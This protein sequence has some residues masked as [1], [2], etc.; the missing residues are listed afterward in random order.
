MA[1]AVRRSPPASG[2]LCGRCPGRLGL[3]GQSPQPRRERVHRGAGTA[4]RIGAPTLHRRD[5]PART[6]S[7]PPFDPSRASEAPADSPSVPGRR[8][9]RR[10]GGPVS[11]RSSQGRPRHGSGGGARGLGTPSAR[12]GARARGP[13]PG[14][15]SA[16]RAEAGCRKGEGGKAQG[17]EARGPGARV[18]R[19]WACVC[20]VCLCVRAHTRLGGSMRIPARIPEAS[21][22]LVLQVRGSPTH[23]R[24]YLS[25]RRYT[26]E[27]TS[28][29][30]QTARRPA[31][32]TPIRRLQ[33]PGPR[34]QA[35]QPCLSG[36]SRLSAKRR[37]AAGSTSSMGAAPATARPAPHPA[38]RRQA[39]GRGNSRVWY[40]VKIK[41]VKDLP[42]NE[43][44]GIP[45]QMYQSTKV[46]RAAP[47]G[48]RH[49]ASDTA[50]GRIRTGN[51]TL[52]STPS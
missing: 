6:A 34:P 24:R 50:Q 49:S 38:V 40:R 23:T 44:L 10:D 42:I 14:P 25:V 16:R 4:R 31:P 8:R 45:R 37:S 48:R 39:R 51:H 15:G 36:S 43:T 12:P 18:V 41:K 5:A 47:Q 33:A 20:V 27:H 35:G 28:K 19:R 3:G 7:S 46:L 29:V 26:T 22:F 32:R 11:A 13:R 52:A 30:Y 1:A 9:R 2:L 17:T 21:V